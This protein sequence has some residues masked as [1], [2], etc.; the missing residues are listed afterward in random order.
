MTISDLWQHGT[1]KE[2]TEHLHQL[3]TVICTQCGRGYTRKTG[4]KCLAVPKI[5]E[6]APSEVKVSRRLG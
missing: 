2:L 1:D 5:D 4:H 6:L 3:A